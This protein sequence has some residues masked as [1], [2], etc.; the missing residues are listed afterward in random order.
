[1]CRRPGGGDGL[2]L[3]GCRPSTAELQYAQ[4]YC[5]SG[6]RRRAEAPLAPPSEAAPHESA[7]SG[8]SPGAAAAS[9]ARPGGGRRG[10][11]AG[12]LEI[13]ETG[14]SLPGF[15]DYVPFALVQYRAN[16]SAGGASWG[17]V[18]LTTVRC[19]DDA[20]LHPP[21]PVL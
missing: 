19:R 16:S 9:A 8:N 12:G 7:G 18:L 11:A 20:L 17:P 1:M 10:F 3:G 14:P 2:R 15:P 13:P 6:R 5:S 21:T 4:A